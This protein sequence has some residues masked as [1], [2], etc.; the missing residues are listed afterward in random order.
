MLVGRDEEEMRER[1]FK[2]KRK[3]NS[4]WVTGYYVAKYDIDGTLIHYIFLNKGI[5]VWEFVEIIPETLCQ[6]TCLTD[7][8]GEKIWENDVCKINE[9][10]IDEEDGN[11]QVEW[12]NDS[13]RF[14]L[15][16][17]GLTVDFDNVYGYECEVI[18][19]IFDNKEL[20]EVE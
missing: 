3:D 9:S 4:E 16:G 13:A 1:L 15:N 18:G 10:S 5:N 19:N 17:F 6:Y 7:K 8:N 14:V 11:F 2:A 20:L 12:D